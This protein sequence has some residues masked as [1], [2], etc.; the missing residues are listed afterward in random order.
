MHLLRSDRTVTEYIDYIISETEE[1]SRQ[2]VLGTMEHNAKEPRL[3]YNL[4][5]VRQSDQQ[6]L[7]WIGIGAAEDPERGELDFGYALLPAYWGQGYATEALA[8]LLEFAFVSLGVSLI[9]GECNVHNTGSAR[10]M[11]KAGMQLK[12][13]VTEIDDESGETLEDFRYVAT[14]KNM[15]M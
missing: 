8:S 9:Y 2:W 5:I 3:S 1:E 12:E 6:I 14:R 13:R 15:D 10:V 11:E 4:T 7:G